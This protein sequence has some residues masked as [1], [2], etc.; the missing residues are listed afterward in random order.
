MCFFSSLWWAAWED[1]EDRNKFWFR[2]TNSVVSLMWFADW[3]DKI[4]RKES[5]RDGLP[6][7]IQ[8][9]GLK[10]LIVHDPIN[11]WLIKLGVKAT[12]VPRSQ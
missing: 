5:R 9:L 3:S 1:I 12:K 8:D 10:E 6:A 2:K 11:S 7:I 4:E